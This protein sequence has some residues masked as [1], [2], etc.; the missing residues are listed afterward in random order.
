MVFALFMF[1]SVILQCYYL[2]LLIL[3]FFLYGYSH[4]LLLLFFLYGYIHILS[5]NEIFFDFMRCFLFN[6]DYLENIGNS[7]ITGTVITLFCTS[8]SNGTTTDPPTSISAVTFIFPLLLEIL[9]PLL[10]EILS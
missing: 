10:L 6:I 1:P 8:T 3:L 9:F 2:L 5:I 4:I 7:T